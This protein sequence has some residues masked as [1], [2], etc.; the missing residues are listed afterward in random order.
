MPEVEL[1]EPAIDPNNRITFLLDWELTLKCNLNCSYCPTGLYGGH[2][3][4]T[5]HPPTLECLA[6]LD[7]MFEYVDLYM[8]TKPKGIRYV[9]LNVYGGESLHHPDIINILSQVRTK[10]QPYSDR[11]HLTVTTTTNAIITDKKLQQIIPLIDEFTVSYHTES[12]EK[13]KQQFKNNL[14][15]IAQSGR[16]QKCV[17]LM[18]EQSDL[19]EDADNMI[20]WLTEHNI[21]LLPRQLDVLS[22]S[23]K[24]R[25]Y[26]QQQVKWFDKLYQ[27]K[28][29]GCSTD[30]LDG[31]NET[32]LADVGRACCGGRQM[33]TNENYKQRH[34]YLE[35][36]FPD[37]YCSVNHFFLYVKQVN[38]EVYV[39]KDCKMN[40]DGEVGPI[41]N[42]NATQQILSILKNHLNAGSL[43]IIQ[44]KKHN[45]FC[46][47]CAPKAKD[48]A[49]YKKIMKKYQK[50]QQL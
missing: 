27:S 46:G 19:F 17:V 1:L 43:P 26:N 34:F 13:Q 8:S 40:F 38:G 18:H 2:D 29:F 31:K 32:S 24:K 47:L 15:T 44:C 9:V 35:N 33:C 41:G 14:L 37:W 3:N 4:S 49:S 6:T 10:Y 23:T 11:W 28:T 48:L 21:K 22:T 50:E 16:R 25:I 45:C 7:F 30:L 42:L 20:S 36:K 39:N 12:T 5:K